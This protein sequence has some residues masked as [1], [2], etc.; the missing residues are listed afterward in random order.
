LHQEK[1]LERYLAN[2]DIFKELNNKL[3]KNIKLTKI[4][5]LPPTSR[6]CLAPVL[7]ER[8]VRKQDSGLESKLES[9]YSN[10]GPS[11]GMLPN[12]YSPNIERALISNL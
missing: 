5:L 1:I 12:K 8:H 3:D 11:H 7:L 9:F 4:P 2:E 6:S 10:Q